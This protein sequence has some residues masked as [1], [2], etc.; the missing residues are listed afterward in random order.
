MSKSHKNLETSG[1]VFG[2]EP[3][4]FKEVAQIILTPTVEIRTDVLSL[5]D[6]VYQS[7]SHE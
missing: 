3:H 7:V 4:D 1:T 6:D 2:E 5:L